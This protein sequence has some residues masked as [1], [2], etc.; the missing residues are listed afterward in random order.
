MTVNVDAVIEKIQTRKAKALKSISMS[1]DLKKAYPDQF[2]KIGNFSGTATLILKEHA[3]I[4]PPRKCSIRIKDKLQG[5]SNNLMK[6]D[7]TKAGGTYRVLPQPCIQHKEGW[8]SGHMLRP[9]KANCQPK[10]VP[11][12]DS[13]S[14][15]I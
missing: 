11:I 2:D 8:T 1:A 12:Q 4:D 14:G 5:E 3:F 9:Q 6:Q 10:E 15:R 7:D 13:N